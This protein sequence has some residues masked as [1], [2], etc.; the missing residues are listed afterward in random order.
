MED[1][2]KLVTASLA[3]HGVECPADNSHSAWRRTPLQPAVA[4]GACG[5]AGFGLPAQ[6]E[7]SALPEHNFRNSSLPDRTP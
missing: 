5:E 7:P 4:T 6:A 3:R 2:I 1:L